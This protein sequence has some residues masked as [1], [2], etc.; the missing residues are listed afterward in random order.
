MVKTLTFKERV[1]GVKISKGEAIRNS[2]EWYESEAKTDALDD[3]PT[4][5][6][7]EPASSSSGPSSA[8]SS[9][10]ATPSKKQKKSA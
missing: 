6:D 1:G 9:A 4:M 10:A 5:D 7:D 2:A 3:I 8:S